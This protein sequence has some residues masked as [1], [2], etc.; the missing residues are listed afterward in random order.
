MILALSM[1]VGAP[2]GTARMQAA[3]AHAIAQGCRV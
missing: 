1:T 3:C 2:I